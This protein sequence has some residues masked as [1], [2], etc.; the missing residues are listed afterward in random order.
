VH[1]F[2]YFYIVDGIYARNILTF[3]PLSWRR[4]WAHINASKW[5]MGFN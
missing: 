2:R 1:F 3:I 5:Q 4:W